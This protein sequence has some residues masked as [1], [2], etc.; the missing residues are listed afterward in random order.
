MIGTGSEDFQFPFSRKEVGQS[1]AQQPS[2]LGSCGLTQKATE[3]GPNI[4]SRFLVIAPA[5]QGPSPPAGY[6][7]C[8]R[9]WVCY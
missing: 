7:Y 6:R 3:A 9:V 2:R 5:S 1:S 8:C 4:R